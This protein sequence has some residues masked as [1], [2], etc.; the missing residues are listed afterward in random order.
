MTAN[1]HLNR[2]LPRLSFRLLQL[3]PLHGDLRAQS[4]KERFE[5]AVSL[6]VEEPQFCQSHVVVTLRLVL[7]LYLK[8]QSRYCLYTW[9]PPVGLPKTLCF[10]WGPAAF[11]LLPN[12]PASVQIPYSG[13]MLGRRA[14][15]PMQPRGALRVG[16]NGHGYQLKL[17]YSRCL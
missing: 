17:W 6:M 14:M 10:F 13:C 7:L 12:Y 9:S 2:R 8:P 3:E 11:V 16:F 1:P 5:V 15:F 4:C